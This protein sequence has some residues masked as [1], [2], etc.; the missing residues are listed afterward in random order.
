MKS[1]PNS[2]SGSPVLQVTGDNFEE[3]VF[4][5]DRDFMLVLTAPKG[6]DMFKGCVKCEP[7]I[8]MLE[9]VSP[10]IDAEVG[11][12]IRFGEFLVTENEIPLFNWGGTW[13]WEE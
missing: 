2:Q 10:A 7:L 8:Q 11:P 5:N 3:M 1:K 6:N 12:L 9:K 4:H 13:S